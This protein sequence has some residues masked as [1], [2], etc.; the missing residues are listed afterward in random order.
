[1]FFWSFFS[2]RSLMLR[3]HCDILLMLLMRPLRI[4]VVDG[5]CASASTLM[6]PSGS[7]LPAMAVTFDEPISIATMKLS[8]VA[9]Y[10]YFFVF[11]FLQ[12]IWLGCSTLRA[13][14][15]FQP[16]CGMTFT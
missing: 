7:F 16:T 1:M 2:K 15:L 8:G 5:S 11:R 3:M 6:P 4:K 10:A 14:Y 13:V 9:I 12:I